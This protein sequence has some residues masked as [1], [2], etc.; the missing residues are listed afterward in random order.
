MLTAMI[1]LSLPGR[2]ALF[3]LAALC[4]AG[5]AWSQP[6]PR[7]AAYTLTTADG[8]PQGVA[9]L[10]LDHE[11]FLWIGTIDGLA[12]W[13]GT[14]LEVYRTQAVP[15][16]PPSGLPDNPVPALAVD[17]SGTVWAGTRRGLTRLRPPNRNVCL[18]R[19]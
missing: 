2:V 9:A 16:K 14:H 5:A 3:V 12:R 18:G 11:G 15:G 6:S 8:L 17:T 1:R 4:A 7:Y 19:V 10:A 13:D